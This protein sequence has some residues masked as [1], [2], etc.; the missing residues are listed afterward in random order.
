M[1]ECLLLLLGAVCC[2]C[3]N[4]KGGKN[5]KK[6]QPKCPYEHDDCRKPPCKKQ[7]QC[8]CCEYCCLPS[9]LYM[10]NGIYTNCKQVKYEGRCCYE[11]TGVYY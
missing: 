2:C 3:D 6:E 11:D 8:E 4:G 5:C 9:R 10:L 1:C 7:C